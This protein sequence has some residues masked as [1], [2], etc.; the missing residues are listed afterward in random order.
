MKFLIHG[1]VYETLLRDKKYRHYQD[2]M[3]HFLY[4]INLKKY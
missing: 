2:E 1:S 4:N 3:K